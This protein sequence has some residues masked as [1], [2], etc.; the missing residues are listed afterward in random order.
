MDLIEMAL[1][2]EQ[3]EKLDTLDSGYK[4]LNAFGYDIKFPDLDNEE[5]WDI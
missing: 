1:N 2:K 4:I 5:N 3:L